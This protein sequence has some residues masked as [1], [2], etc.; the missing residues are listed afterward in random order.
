MF[1]MEAEHSGDEA[2]L[3]G[4]DVSDENEYDRSFVTDGDATQ[5]PEDY[6]QDA[7]YRQGLMTQAPAACGLAFRSG[8]VR[9][10]QYTGGA[11]E[12][13]RE[14]Q[15]RR[16]RGIKT[17][18]SPGRSS[19]HDEYEMGSFVVEDDDGILELSSER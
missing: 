8:P 7:I 11:N 4:S 10:G 18:S 12:L 1:E 3:G 15:R 9:K 17:S 14:R 19:E 13:A 5:A 16:K 6:D 2:S